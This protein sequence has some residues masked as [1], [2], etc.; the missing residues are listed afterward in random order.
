MI[1]RRLGHKSG[2]RKASATA[3]MASARFAFIL[4]K[5]RKEN[6]IS[7][8]EAVSRKERAARAALH[9]VQNCGSCDIWGMS[10]TKSPIH[11]ILSEAH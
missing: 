10:Y 5:L 1:Q 8:P 6:R 4:S 11:N 3:K 7:T 2:E 9:A